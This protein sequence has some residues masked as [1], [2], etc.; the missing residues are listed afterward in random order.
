MPHSTCAE[1]T[2]PDAA[3][4]GANPDEPQAT[5]TRIATGASDSTTV[6]ITLTAFRGGEQRPCPSIH[7]WCPCFAPLTTRSMRI[8]YFHD[9]R[10][11]ISGNEPCVSC[12]LL[13]LRDV[14]YP[15]PFSSV[16]V[17]FAGEE[18]RSEGSR[19]PP[20]LAAGEGVSTGPTPVLSNACGK[21]G[22]LGTAN[23]AVRYWVRKSVVTRFRLPLPCE[24]PPGLT[25][26]P[27]ASPPISAGA[28]L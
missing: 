6:P 1:C 27:P 9:R 3:P 20:I 10:F 16:G 25:I 2:R 26:Q 22:L 15:A 14:L 28:F 21:P 4:R 8:L 23:I 19:T 24:A 18:G 13:H 12:S 7:C 5:E 17:F 11:R